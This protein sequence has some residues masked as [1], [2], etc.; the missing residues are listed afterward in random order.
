MQKDD[1]DWTYLTR[2]IL[3]DGQKMDLDLELW[4]FPE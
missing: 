2:Y 1:F 3:S 4:E